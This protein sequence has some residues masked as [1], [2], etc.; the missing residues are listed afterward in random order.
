MVVRDDNGG[1]G[2]LTLEAWKHLRPDVT[3]VVQS[4]PCRGEPH[5]ETFEE[6][7]TQVVYADNPVPSSTWEKLSGM[8]DVWWTAETWYNDFAESI[9]KS[10]G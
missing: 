5:P 9:L 2:N 3:L 6:A 8:A 7:W 4:R 10:A 1:L